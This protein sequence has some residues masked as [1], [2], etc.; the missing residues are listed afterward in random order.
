V[1]HRRQ[2][3]FQMAKAAILRGVFTAILI[4]INALCEPPRS[5]A[6]AA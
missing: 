5:G 4:M 1:R 2:A 6:V 3:I